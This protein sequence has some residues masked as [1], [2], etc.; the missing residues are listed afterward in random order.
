LDA[1]PPINS[2]LFVAVND[3][4]TYRS[5]VEDIDSD[6]LTVA[7]PIGAGD[8]DVP[9]VGADVAVF[10]V[11]S[12]TRYVLPV[13]MVGVT[14]QRPARWQIQP[15]GQPQ[16]ET[17]RRF[18]RGGGGKPIRLTGVPNAGDG[19]DF[20]TVDPGEGMIADISEGGVRCRMPAGEFTPGQRVTVRISLDG[21]N[22]EVAGTVH[23]VRPDPESGQPEVI[24]TYELPE[25]TAQIIRRYVFSW[26]LAERRRARYGD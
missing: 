13:R 22:I 9:E 15:T 21:S 2:L 8:I 26:E 12:R 18:V 4:T 17:R 23:T 16:P 20:T 3:E 6:I 11:G 19:L 10:W 14:R 25:E 5:R 24:V 7:A 1:L